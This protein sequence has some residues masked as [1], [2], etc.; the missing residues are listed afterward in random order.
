M[1][2]GWTSENIFLMIHLQIAYVTGFNNEGL[3]LMSSSQNIDKSLVL[4]LWVCVKENSSSAERG[5]LGFILG[6]PGGK[7]HDL[8]QGINEEPFRGSW[9]LPAPTWALCSDTPGKADPD[10]GPGSHNTDI[11]VTVQLLFLS[12]SVMTGSKCPGAQLSGCQRA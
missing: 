8:E 7:M 3:H 2:L 11:L 10:L 4:S 6:F 5:D 1:E 12:H 9:A